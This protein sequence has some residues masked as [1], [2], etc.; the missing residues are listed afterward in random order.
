MANGIE[1]MRHMIAWDS[2]GGDRTANHLGLKPLI[3]PD[4]ISK[5]MK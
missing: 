5:V 1:K 2:H 4:H 3:E